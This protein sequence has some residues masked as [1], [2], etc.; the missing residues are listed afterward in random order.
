MKRL[1]FKTLKKSLSK[2]GCHGNVKR[3]GQALATLN[4]SQ[5]NFRKSHEVWW[6]WLA[7]EKSYKRPK[8]VRAQSPSPSPVR[9]GLSSQIR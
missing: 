1:K 8:A 6:V 7:Y 3:D 4:C 9:I 2:S 5:I